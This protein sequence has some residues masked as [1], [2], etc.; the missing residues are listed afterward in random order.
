MKTSGPD[1]AIGSLSG[2]NQQ[3]VVIG[4]MLATR[5]HVILLD[6]PSLG[7]APIIIKGIFEAIVEINKQGT[8]IL[9]VEQN[10]KIALATANR[11]YVMQT[12]EIVL[13]DTCKNLEANEEVK[14]AYLGGE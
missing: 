5:P 9:F 14:K 12:G 10:S 11:G 6:E 2:G 4:K 3:K 7:L 13:T 8:T 1:A